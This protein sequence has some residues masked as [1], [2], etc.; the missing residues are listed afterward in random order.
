MAKKNKS[1]TK[2]QTGLI[3][4]F[5]RA[6]LAVSAEHRKKKKNLSSGLKMEIIHMGFK[7]ND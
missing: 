3:V 5:S 6:V 4:L 7:S 1:K 2:T